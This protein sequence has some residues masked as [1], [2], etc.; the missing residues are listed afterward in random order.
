MNR[1]EATEVR[2]RVTDTEHQRLLEALQSACGARPP[3]TRMDPAV[4]S[5]KWA[6]NWIRGMSEAR[7]KKQAEPATRQHIEEIVAT[8]A[9]AA[10]Q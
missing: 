3:G 2:N 1:W 7:L 9:D 4:A 5:W 10:F 6:F 8:Y